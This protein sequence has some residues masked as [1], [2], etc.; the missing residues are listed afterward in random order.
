[1]KRLL[2]VLPL[3]IAGCGNPIEARL[4]RCKEEVRTE[5]TAF[6][7]KTKRDTAESLE[8][9][10]HTEPADLPQAPEAVDAVGK[11]SNDMIRAMPGMLAAMAAPMIE[12]QLKALEPTAA[13]LSKCQEILDQA[14]QT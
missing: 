1:M 12:A 4:N 7:E 2:L 10:E 13:G 9:L 5:L 8:T 14:R 6:L 3:A 11:F